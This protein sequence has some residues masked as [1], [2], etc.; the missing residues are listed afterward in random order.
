MIVDSTAQ[1]H[2][3]YDFSEPGTPISDPADNQLFSELISTSA[4]RRLKSIRFLGGIDYLFVRSPNGIKGNIRYT[5]YQHSLGVA[6]L[7]LFYSRSRALNPSDR[8]LVLAAALLHDVGHAPLSHSL[9]PVFAEVFGLDHHG[10]TKDIVSGRAHLGREVYETLRR[11]QISVERVITI[12]AGD[13]QGFDGFFAGPINFDTIEGILRSQTFARPSASIPSPE[14]VTEA[15]IKRAD[16]K[17]RDMVDEFW[18]YKDKVYRHVINSRSGTL[19]DFACQFFMRRHLDDLNEGDYLKTEGQ[20]F[21]KLPGLRKLLTSHSFEAEVT[22]LLD[23]PITYK[24]RRF[25]I[26]PSA[27]FFAHDDRGRYQQVKVDGRL[28]PPGEAEESAMPLKRD[29]FA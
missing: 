22:R 15:A 26:E 24:A 16:E 25:F 7:A 2:P 13:E 4:L 17:D 3:V 9:E 27:D 21:R 5:R 29:L 14:S 18:A 8:R 10:V 11:N 1:N 19:A 12:I 6:R 20:I 28:L 23:M